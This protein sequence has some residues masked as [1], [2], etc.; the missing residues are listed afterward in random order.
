[1]IEVPALLK[2]L[3]ESGNEPPSQPTQLAQAGASFRTDAR[4][5]FAHSMET[6]ANIQ[7]DSYAK[8]TAVSRYTGIAPDVL[9]ANVDRM[10]QLLKGNEYAAIYDNARKTADALRDGNLAA[11]AQDDLD[12]LQRIERASSDSRFEM[13]STGEKLVNSLKAAWLSGEQGSAIGG[14]D[15][16]NR[17]SKQFD[18]V[19]QEIARAEQAGEQPY[20]GQYPFTGAKLD[21]LRGSPEE[22]QLMRERLTGRQESLLSGVGERQA[23]INEIPIEPGATRAQELKQ[24]GIGSLA[25]TAEAIGENPGYALRTALGASASSAPMLVAGAVGGIPAAAAVEFGTEYNAKLLDVFGEKGVDLKDP[26]AVLTALQD[27]AF[28]TDARQ[29][30]AR[31]A[32]G[33]TAVDIVSMGLA[34]KLLVPSKVAGRSL[35]NTQ[36]EMANILVQVPVQGVT[37]GAS[38]AAGQF[39]ADQKVDAGEVLLEAVAGGAHSTLD[40]LTFGGSRVWENLGAGLRDAR[41]ARVGKESLDQM[42]EAT[43]NGKT[44]GRDPETFNTIAKAQLVDSP[45]ETLWI[46]AEALQCLNQEGVDLTTLMQNVPGLTEQFADAVARGGSVEMKTADYLTTF[47]DYHEQLGNQVRIKVDG[48]STDDAVAWTDEQEQQLRDLSAQIATQ[49]D[50]QAAAFNDV[51]GQLIQAGFRRQDAE[52]YAATHLSVIN[53]LAE[54]T[55]Q[56]I[57]DITGQFPLEIRQQAP[58]PLQQFSEAQVRDALAEI[59][60]EAPAPTEGEAP[61]APTEPSPA[62][63]QLR[64]YLDSLGIDLAQTSDEDVISLLRQPPAQ[65]GQ[66]LEQFAG[67]TAWTADTASLNQAQQQ[68]ADGANPEQVRKDTGWFQGADGRWRFEIDD[69]AATFHDVSGWMDAAEDGGAPLQDVLNHPHLF[70]A[71]PE[72]GRVRVHVDP[73]RTAGAMFIGEPGRGFVGSTIEIGDPTSYPAD[74]PAMDSLTHEVQHA[75]QA[76]EGF[77]QGGDPETLR[78]EKD[79]ALADRDYWNQ[80][81]DLR[82]EIDAAGGDVQTG[83]Q[84]FIDTFERTPT[85]QQMQD[86]QGAEL[87]QIEQRAAEAERVMREIG[88]PEQTYQRLAGEVEARNTAARRTMTAEERQ[89]ASP[90]QTADVASSRAIVRWGDTEMNSRQVA[91]QGRQ[92]ERLN[93]GGENDQARGFIT[94]T[95]RGEQNRRFQIVLGEKRDLST[96]LHEF[97]HYYLEVM[98]DLAQSP[99]APAQIT[100]DVA[101]IRSWLG[102]EGDAPLTTDQHE[103]FARGFEA[104]LAEGKAPSPE[105]AGAFAR[106][107]RWLIQVYKDLTRL[108]VE[109]NDD[110][111][112]VFDRLVATDDQI[113]QA[114]QVTQAMPLFADAQAAG[115]TEAEFKAYQDSIDIAHA[116]AQ[117]SVEREIQQEE[118]RR[119]SKWWNERKDEV[120]REVTE[121]VDTLPEYAALRALRRG[122]MPD[123]QEVN[124]KLNSAEL[125]ERFGQSAAQRLAF[126]YAKNGIPLDDAARL[127]GWSSGDEM[128]QAMLGAPNRGK[129]IEDETLARMNDRYGPA[130]TGEA[131]DRAINAV[132]NDRR[133]DVMVKELQALAKAGNRRNFTSQQILKEAARRVMAERKVRAIQPAEFQRAEAKA[134]RQ[135]YEALLKGDLDTAYEAKQRQ[136]LNFHM[137]REAVKARAEIE[138]IV[139][140]MAKYNKRSTRERIGKAGHDYLDQIDAVMEQYEF[141]NVSL[142]Q[143]DKAKSAASWYAEQVTAGNDPFV[144]EFVLNTARKVNYKDLSLDQLQELDE[145]VANIAHLA[146]TKNK[147]LK[148]SVIKDLKEGRSLLAASAFD[149]VRKL[150]RRELVQNARTLPQIATDWLKR[151]NSSLIKMEQAFEWLDGGD[152]NGPWKTLIFNPLAEAQH[153]ADDLNREYTRRVTDLHAQWIKERGNSVGERFHVKSIN[154]AMTTSGML[155]VALNTGNES[156]RSKLLNGYGWDASVLDEILGHMKAEDWKYVEGLWNTVESLW[157][158]IEALEKRVNGIAPP[159]IEGLTITNQFGTFKG[160]YWPLVYDPLSTKYADVLSTMGGLAPLGEGGTVR[161]TPP[162]GHTQARIDSFNAPILL[163]SSVI[164]NHLNQVIHDLTHREALYDARRLYTNEAREAVNQ[165]LGPDM[166]A[167][168]VNMLD[169][170][171]TGQSSGNMKAISTFAKTMNALR[172]NQSLA[173]MGYSITTVFNQLSGYSQGL[174]YFAAKGDRKYIYK[175][176]VKFWAAPIENLK[177][178]QEMSGEMRNRALNLDVSIREAQNQVLRMK[179]GRVVQDAFKGMANARD[180]MVK[181]A[182]VPMQTMQSV[183]DG[184]VWMAGYE[185]AGG[186]NNHEAA[187]LAADRAVRLTQTAG[188]AKDLA[189]IQQNVLAKL[190]MPVYGYASLLWNRNVDIARAAGQGFRDRSPQQVLVAFERFVYLNMIPAMIAGLIGGDLPDPDGGDDDETWAQW[191]AIKGLSSVTQGIP[192][193]GPAV[194]SVFSP[195]GYTGAS[196][197]GQGFDALIKAKNSEKDQTITTNAINAVGVFTGLPASQVN[198][199]VRT[200]F[201]TENGEMDD[202][203]LSVARALL[204]GPP[205]K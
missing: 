192:V 155:A 41:Q 55:G 16:L 48:M 175:A 158:Q 114:E 131:A 59:R 19:D 8:A 11:I 151:G 58:E 64:T 110:I 14:V 109:I 17:L 51:L 127:L 186:S 72:I 91:Q 105:L 171:A 152:P 23:A 148:N 4:M 60:T 57:S 130:T 94:F 93:Q 177:M 67:P 147:L 174:E 99:D 165:T 24:Q 124:F 35:S 149:S 56:A 65:Q 137:Y 102:A 97:G 166:A 179:D 203:A 77:A 145:Y 108:N 1:M 159:K 170:I 121:E 112:R 62:A 39:A 78:A 184:V 135:A 107:K 7:P 73:Q 32:A 12:Q 157:P 185:Q 160:G 43:L 120:R 183:V 163:D 26:K 27:E 90:E 182:F 191:L 70:A 85:E 204:F 173:W 66:R 96:V 198:R 118:E 2:P 141:R 38:E 61:A 29:R 123:G 84:Q 106:F 144:P 189:T 129:R 74:A 202:S 176:F 140:R 162:R 87:A 53:S 37:E 34:S 81:A 113:T 5:D 47:A 150:P 126:T 86:A 169:G 22:R 180:V 205:K 46:P 181:Y 178:I 76:R 95:P 28:M 154:Q 167:Q 98:Q 9:H 156:N 193:V 50:A 18:V 83:R 164:A 142:R 116:N 168:F 103:Q 10:N 33:T 88:N 44:R 100:N 136:L 6:V 117:E 42:V 3:D 63:R 190:F 82:R 111:R 195:Y 30:A 69:S 143:L 139:D 200:Y 146:S 89:A 197:I 128:I 36:R 79:Q 31:K 188:G 15:Q 20:G 52:Q 172:S 133:A 80:V 104:Y 21:Y 49:P 134:G 40:V 194:A 92:A 75:I 68:I 132:H 125:N 115:M 101:T 25:A 199:A 119:R 54:R 201:M 196:P 138:K 122:V 187:V 71:Y 13:Q 153:N 161:S 45:M